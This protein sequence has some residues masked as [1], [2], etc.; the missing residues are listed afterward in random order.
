AGLVAR[1]LPR[2]AVGAEATVAPPAAIDLDHFQKIDL[3]VALI[4]E[5]RKHPKAEKL[6]VLSVD[7]GEGRP[8]QVVAGLAGAYKPEDLV[9]RRGILVGDFKPA[10]I[11]GILSEGVIL[12]PGADPLVAL[13]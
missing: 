2:E 4:T 12:A 13:A 5:A 9:G 11:P 7:A 10:T 1:W 8:R 6:Y 3:R